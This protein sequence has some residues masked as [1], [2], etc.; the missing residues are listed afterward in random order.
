MVTDGIWS[1]VVL[2]E[3]TRILNTLIVVVVVVV[4]ELIDTHTS[5]VI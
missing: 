4:D 3:K 5:T 2:C 1:M